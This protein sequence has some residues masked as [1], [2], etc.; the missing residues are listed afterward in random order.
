M[1][2]FLKELK[3]Y[4]IVIIFFSFLLI[5]TVLDCCTP[6]VKFDE[7]SNSILTQRPTFSFSSLV[8]NKYTKEYEDYI[9]DQFA[10]RHQWINIK[11]RIESMLLKRENNGVI[12]GKDHYQFTKMTAVDES[13]MLRSAEVVAEFSARH[14]GKVSLILA[15]SSSYILA[16]KLPPAAPF[17]DEGALTDKV[18][19][20]IGGSA[21]IIDIRPT[22]L[23]H[24]DEYI[25][26]RTD[27]H[28]TTDGAYLAYCDFAAA[29][30]F[31]PFDTQSVEPVTVENF[32][33][34]TY[35]K[36]LWHNTVADEIKYYPLDNRMD[37]YTLD[38]DRNIES[39]QTVGL[40]DTAKFDVRDKYA[41]F[42]YSNN[43]LSRIYGNGT[44]KVLVIKDSYAN[45]FVP[46][47]TANYEQ[48]DVVDLRGLKSNVEFLIEQN[49]YD[50]ILLLYS[51]Q[52]FSGLG[53]DPN[54]YMLNYNVKSE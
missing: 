44:G 35:S 39:T 27:H 50:Q 52:S 18:F 26:Y 34:T 5:Y 7:Y 19:D 43:A 33:G 40:Y 20:A 29:M 13:K 28:W 21:N 49:D 6:D 41:A 15:P 11:S 17:A 37:I 51:F 46:F 14:H 54:I 48:I 42:L 47:L 23:E 25:Y 24:N 1:K 4:P 31:T 3:N 12:Y 53:D 30:G 38:M 2:Q 45:C 22:L 9:T 36:S 16:D 8:N 10:F 32:L